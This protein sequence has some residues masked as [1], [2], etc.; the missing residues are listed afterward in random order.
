MI[1]VWS[2]LRWNGIFSLVGR[3]AGSSLDLDGRLLHDVLCTRRRAESS[4]DLDSRLL[5]Y[6]RHTRRHQYRP[7][8]TTRTRCNALQCRSSLSCGWL[9]VAIIRSV[10][11]RVT[12]LVRVGVAFLAAGLRS[13]SFEGLSLVPLIAGRFC[14]FL[15]RFVVR[16]VP[17]CIYICILA[18][19]LLSSPLLVKRVA[20]SWNV[21]AVLIMGAGLR[22]SC[23][24]LRPVL[25]FAASRPL[26]SPRFPNNPDT[27]S[28]G[29]NKIPIRLSMAITGSC[30]PFLVGECMVL[31]DILMTMIDHC[32][33]QIA[34]SCQ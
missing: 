31:F 24:A 4:L 17:V 23:V 32:L 20:S 13:S 1:Q 3:R 28:F 12:L 8:T 26:G 5:L 11:A 22:V 33:I 16:S 25:D 14:V 21:I 34:V 2:S 7:G 15:A 30:L 27:E 19:R 9:A 6:F 10:L 18:F 29:R